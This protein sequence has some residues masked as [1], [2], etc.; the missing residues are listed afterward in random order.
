MRY[1]GRSGRKWIHFDKYITETLQ[2]SAGSNKPKNNRCDDDGSQ[3]SFG[4]ISAKR[5]KESKC[6][7]DQGPCVN[8]PKWSL[9]TASAIHGC[10]GEGSG[11]WNADQV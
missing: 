7:E 5:H 3:T 1:S 11:D 10:A 9:D 4:Y 8:T 6:Q 2:T